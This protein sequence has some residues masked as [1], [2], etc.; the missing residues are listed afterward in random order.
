MPPEPPSDPPPRSDRRRRPTTAW[1]A[2]RPGGRR[3]SPRRVE[4]LRQHY[5]VDLIDT[6]T[7]VLAVLLLILTVIDGAIT[8]VLLKAGCEEVNP[9]MEY[10]L[11]RGPLSFL[12]GKY[13][14]TT[15]ALPFLLIF[16]HFTLFQTRFRVGHLLAVFVALYLI[17][18]GYQIVL[19]KLTVDP[20]QPDGPAAN[21]NYCPT[22]RIPAR[23]SS[24][25]EG[26]RRS[27][28]PEVEGATLNFLISA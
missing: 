27:P 12:L 8:L 21:L 16:R 6:S 11:R 9:A 18:L 20:G 24:S 2:F 17:L 25:G 26:L 15:A 10:L 1:D 3:I 22:V 28:W 7:F 4:E 23:L 14:L 19:M 13:A 5:F